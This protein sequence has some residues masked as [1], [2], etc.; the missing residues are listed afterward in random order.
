MPS[1]FVNQHLQYTHGY[2]AVLA[3]ISESGVNADGTP[4]F[5]LSNLPP[6]GTPSLSETGLADLLRRRAATRAATSSPTPR[7]PSST[8]RTTPASEVTNNYSGKGGVEAGSIV[9]RAAFALR[10][11]DPNFILSGQI[12]PSS[13]VMYNRNI[14]TGSARRPRSSSTTPTPTRSSSTA[15]VLGHRRLHHH[16]QLPVLPERQHG[17]HAGVAAG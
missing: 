15:G 10:F 16:R 9:R 7:P 1:G 3:P 2:G 4:N 13:R 6:T 11:G 17:R 8:T 5:T 14:N 12:T